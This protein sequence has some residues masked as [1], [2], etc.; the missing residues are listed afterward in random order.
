MDVAQVKRR[1]GTSF[2]GLIKSEALERSVK[3]RNENRMREA[4]LGLW[5]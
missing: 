1:V 4:L 5:I 3:G 2:V